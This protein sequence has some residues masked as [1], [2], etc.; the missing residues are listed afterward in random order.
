[1]SQDSDIG[2]RLT[3]FNLGIRVVGRTGRIREGFKVGE[4]QVR[5]FGSLLPSTNHSHLSGMESPPFILL[6]ESVHQEFGWDTLRTACLCSML[7]EPQVAGSETKGKGLKAF[8]SGWLL[9]SCARHV[10]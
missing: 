3:N 6:W 9:H 10:G 7:S 4:I 2:I 5:L 1:M 8:T